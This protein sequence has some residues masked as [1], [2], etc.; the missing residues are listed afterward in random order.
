MIADSISGRASRTRR[1]RRDPRERVAID[2][3]DDLD[4]LRRR[5]VASHSRC[6]PDNDQ[7][8][9]A[10]FCLQRWLSLWAGRYRIRAEDCAPRNKLLPQR[11]PAEKLGAP[12]AL[13]A[14]NGF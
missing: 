4:L 2:C 14:A 8:N 7:A 1:A 13:C 3:P 10:Q 12:A 6:G 11:P 5:I 9:R